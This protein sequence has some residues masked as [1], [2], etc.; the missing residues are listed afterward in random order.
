M[1]EFFGAFKELRDKIASI[2]EN[3]LINTI[4]SR[5]EYQD[6][7]INRNTQV[8]LFELNIDSQGVKLA[9]NRSGYSDNTLRISQ[10]EGRPKRGR[11]RVDLHDTGDYYKSHAVDIG[12]LKDDYFTM[13]SD[14]QKDDTDLVDEWGDI[15]GLTDESMNALSVFILVEFLPL[16]LEE[17]QK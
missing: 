13:I 2:N 15:L 3:A 1:G 17:I 6:F 12:S 8:Q 14:A 9:A 5:K 10:E 11:D 16:L 4:L 7:I